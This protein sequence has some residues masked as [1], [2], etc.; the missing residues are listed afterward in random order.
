MEQLIKLLPEHICNQIAA[1]EVI[2][3]PASVVKELVEN[4]IDAGAT[5]VEVHIKNAGKTLIQVIDNGKGMSLV[6]TR[7]A[8]ERHATSKIT[9][10]DDLFSLYTKGFRGEALASIASISHVVLKTKRREDEVGTML[11]N[12]G[13]VIKAQEPF[14]CNNGTNFE[15]KN[16][17]FN[18]PARRNFLKSDS[19]EFGHIEE[20]FLRIAL[21]HDEIG[22]SLFHNDQPVYQLPQS[23]SRKR[24]VDIFGKN[25][26]DRLVPIEEKTDIVTIRGFIGKPEFAKK[27]RGQQY[28]F[29]NHRYFRDSYFHNAVSSAF[30]NLIA[31]KT[32][33]AY[34]IRFDIDPSRIDVNVHPTKTEIKFEHH[35]EIYSILKSAT[36]QALGKFNIFPTL[37]FEQESA[38]DLPYDMKFQQAVEPQ[39]KVDPSYNPFK[40]AGTNSGSGISKYKAESDYANKSLQAFGFGQQQADAAAWKD[41]YEINEEK[42]EEQATLLSEDEISEVQLN[43]DEL[44]I[45]KDLALLPVNDQLWAIHLARANER[46]VYDQL[47]DTFF[48]QAIAAQR[49]LF[50]IEIAIT[51]QEGMVWTENQKMIARLGFEWEVHDKVIEVHSVPAL[52]SADEIPGTIQAIKDRLADE[53]FEKGEV[54]HLLIDTIASSSS[55]SKKW[56]KLAAQSMLEAWFESKDQFSTPRGAKIMR[57]WSTQDLLK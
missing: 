49:L 7:M 56:S 19:I 25:M 17:F 2:Q 14:V 40:S 24:I 31:E 33:P 39:I 53:H 44:I 26:N 1:G 43:W 8:F 51:H 4:A 11:V 12:D 9:N 38:F 30:D 35:K 27:T 32:F 20:E 16:L 41:F 45:L 18:V 46:V 48:I 10:V 37:D 42:S 3:R 47:F 52:L 57:I 36:K 54:A 55:T 13:G 5:M 22:L 29:V 15:I 28:F 34:F 23:N 50:P 6:D 21:I